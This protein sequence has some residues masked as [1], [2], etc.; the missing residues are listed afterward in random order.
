[1]NNELR[2]LGIIALAVILVFLVAPLASTDPDGLKKA[3]G[4]LNAPEEEPAPFIALGNYSV[5]SNAFIGGLVVLML[6]GAL[7][8]GMASNK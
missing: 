1:L 8:Y 2:F 4:E 7:F 5:P 6:T 3:I